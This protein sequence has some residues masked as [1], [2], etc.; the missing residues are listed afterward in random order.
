MLFK[1]IKHNLKSIFKSILPFIVLLLATVI[2]FNVTAYT[3]ESV[4]VDDERLVVDIIH[5]SEIQQFLHGLFE[6][7]ISCSLILLFAFTVRAIWSR[8]R[9]NFYGDE[10]YLTH[11]L[12]VARRTLWN[13]QILSVL[14]AFLGVIL[15]MVLS[16]LFLTL[17]PSGMR[18]LD[19]LGLVGGC[20]HCVGTYYY[21]EPLELSFYLIYGFIVFIELTFLTLCGVTAIIIKNRV[22]NKLALLSGVVIYMLCSTLLLGIFYAIGQFDQDILRVFDGVPFRTPGLEID[23][24]YMTRA[25]LY[26]GLIYCAYCT[27]LYFVDQK[28]L[29]RGINLD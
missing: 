2:L 3:T 18:L 7:M 20:A 29:K 21:V 19:S 28:L 6:F 14:V 9:N 15:V 22:G 1:L 12:P 4:V 5:A 27:A 13:A 17:T 8:F 25:L 23:M 11:T 24:S 16:C 26:I 10:A